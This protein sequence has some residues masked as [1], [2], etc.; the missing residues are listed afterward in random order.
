M[1]PASLVEDAGFR[2]FMNVVCPAFHVPG[3]STIERLWDKMTGVVKQKVDRHLLMT[4]L[5]DL[6]QVA[7]CAKEF[8]DIAE[9]TDLWTS[10][11]NSAF[12]GI[13]GHYLTPDFALKSLTL[14][15]KPMPGASTCK[16]IAINSCACVQRVTPL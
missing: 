6:M 3:R 16:G 8:E 7:G 5:S 12:L 4:C 10:R 1:R 9:T 2:E 14:A 13:T 11:Y 15:V